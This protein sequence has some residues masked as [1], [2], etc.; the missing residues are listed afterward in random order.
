MYACMRMHAQVLFHC[1]FFFLI[2]LKKIEFFP[3][4]KHFF[5]LIHHIRAGCSVESQKLRPGSQVGQTI[6]F[7]ISS[8]TVICI[9]FHEKRLPDFT[10][11]QSNLK[12]ILGHAKYSFQFCTVKVTR[13]RAVIYMVIS[14]LYEGTYSLTLKF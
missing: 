6:T 8:K 10:C 12:E 11:H 5:L 3:L 14:F 13:C 9:Y 2:F 7:I 1:D 4:G